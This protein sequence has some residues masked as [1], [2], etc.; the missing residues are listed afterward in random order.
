MVTLYERGEKNLRQLA[1]QFGVSPQA[2]QKGLKSR[3]I[4]RASRL[5]EVSNEVDDAARK[6]RERQIQ[7]ANAT[8]ENYAKWYDAIAK[9]TM[10]KVI[11]A[12]TN[13]NMSALN[14][15]IITLKNATAILE[16]ARSESWVIL[17]IEELLGE[18]AELPDLNVGEYTEAELEQIREGN[19]ASYLEGFEDEENEGNDDSLDD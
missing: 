2:I 15:D 10:K 4:E 11:D 18:N 17:G 5:A 7:M 9:L 1:E 12:N 14:A 6:E 19:E 8:R 13:G 16:K 3:G